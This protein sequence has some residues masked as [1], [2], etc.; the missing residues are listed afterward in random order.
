MSVKKNKKYFKNNFVYSEK[1]RIFVV[2]LIAKVM[3][4]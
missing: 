1:S 2:S 3:V 4:N